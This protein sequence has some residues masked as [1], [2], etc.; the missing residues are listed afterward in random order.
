MKVLFIWE[1]GNTAEMAEDEVKRI[2]DAE[3]VYGIGDEFMRIAR[4]HNLVP[5]EGSLLSG[6]FAMDD[7]TEMFT[8][9]LW[10]G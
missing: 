9:T 7:D 3:P 6:V 10:E 2:L 1:T 4:E 8:E 5:A